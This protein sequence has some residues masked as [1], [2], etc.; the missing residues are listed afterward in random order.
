MRR[1]PGAPAWLCLLVIAAAAACSD[2]P[3]ISP[4]AEPSRPS[5][6]LVVIDT[7]RADR[8][9]CYGYGR[10]TS[11]SIDALASRGVV[12]DHAQSTSSWTVPS[13]GSMFTG[14][15]AGR[16]GAGRIRGRSGQFLAHDAEKEFLQ[17]DETL[18]TLAEILRAHGYATGA[19]A[20]NPWLES[21]P[22]FEK[23]FDDY[24]VKTRMSPGES[25]TRLALDW[26]DARQGEQQGGQP[27][28]QPV[29]LFVH[30]M[31]PHSPYAPGPKARGRFSGD[32]S[33]PYPVTPWEVWPVV[34]ELTARQ[35]AFISDAYDEEVLSTDGAVARLI[36][37]IEERGLA[38]DTLVVVTSDHGEELF[39]RGGFD[40][41]HS[42]HGE[43]LRIPLIVSGLDLKPRRVSHAVSIQDLPQ[44][45]LEAA[46]VPEPHRSSLG[47]VSLWPLLRGEAPWP[48]RPLIAAG[49]IYGADQRSITRWPFK[50]I[51]TDGAEPKLYDLAS[52]PGEQHELSASH[53]MLRIELEAEL[54]RL[55]TTRAEE[56]VPALELDEEQREA[57]KG[58]GYVADP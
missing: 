7:L 14:H 36:S 25:I 9:G 17:P 3:S 21:T 52:D 40:H 37:G 15:S 24:T 22:A 42:L 12:F 10:P 26:L 27:G 4:A 30:L 53:E 46:G 32:P 16:H 1:P 5:I 33:G 35:R 39:D 48:A 43:V 58:L 28:G 13:I 44:T 54:A 8:L 19:I 45:L 29:F 41:G 20:S 6:L 23:G 57:L 11:P 47:G 38:E 18:P 56:D 50:L 55:G 49:T 31:T 2:E 34:D 51:V